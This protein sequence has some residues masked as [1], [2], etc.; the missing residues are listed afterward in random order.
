MRLV[1]SNVV[2]YAEHHHGVVFVNHVVAV[3]G[4]LAFEVAE[5][6]VHLRFHVV[7][8]PENVFPAFLNYSSGCWRIS[9]DGK[10]L[11]F[12]EMHVDGML[13]AT[14]VV[15]K[16][17]LLYG[18][19]LDREARRRIATAHELAVDLPLPITSLEPEVRE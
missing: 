9:V 3:Q 18:V 16:N 1:V 12:F 13:P 8:Q 14:R 11:E 17:P 4:E 5:T 10:R 6:E 2:D 19:S 7:L 15:L